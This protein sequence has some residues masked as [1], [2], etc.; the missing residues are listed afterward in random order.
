MSLKSIRVKSSIPVFI[1]AMTFILA[2]FMFDHLI[3]LE[4]TALEE[5]SGRY[6]GAIS[7]VLKADSNLYQAKVAE[8]NLLN[9]IGD[10][11]TQHRIHGDKVQEAS[12]R[13]KEYLDF[14]SVNPELQKEFTDLNLELTAWHQATNKLIKSGT[15]DPNYKSLEADASKLFDHIRKRLKIAGEKAISTAQ[16]SREKVLTEVLEFGNFTFAILAIASL[17]VIFISYRMPKRLT[18]N[19]NNVTLRIREIADGDGDLTARIEADSND[20]IGDLAHEFNHFVDKLQKL[21]GTVQTQSVALGSVTGHLIESA[22][23]TESI[24][25]ALGHASD[26]TVNAG[27]EMSVSNQEMAT[28]AEATSAEARHSD[29]I[30][31]Q[32]ISAVKASHTAIQDL[33]TDIDGALNQSQLLEQS[34][35]NIA[36]VLE[37]IRTIAEQTNLLALNAAIEAA[38]AGEQ[39]RGFAVVADEVRTLATRTQDSTNDIQDMIEQLKS[40]VGHASS[41][42]IRSKERA[43]ETVSHIDQVN[44][45]FNE[46]QVS[47]AKVQDLSSQT[48]K[49]TQE[50]SDVSNM[51]SQSM[52]SLN[53]QTNAAKNVVD[54]SRKQADE[55][56]NLYQ[57]LD[58]VVGRFKV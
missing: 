58:Q 46:L 29:D 55:V 14:M 21:I 30:S 32:G 2:L 51:I 43:D 34:S 24:T 7:S 15:Y 5:Q 33:V 56:E 39:G 37:V 48:A 31:N 57:A 11:P 9:Q 13:I 6:Q 19:I 10:V 53:E 41:A 52:A 47:F 26:S 27:N 4:E 8:L 12:D 35:E 54:A 17:I 42:I 18:Q 25:Q 16:K 36:S 44:T 28:M 20:E 22:K 49:A 3:V 23:Q 1:L 50:Q 40:N 38:R 45:I